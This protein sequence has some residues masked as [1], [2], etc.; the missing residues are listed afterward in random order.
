MKNK[1][2]KVFF[3]F[4]YNFLFIHFINSQSLPPKPAY[5]FN[6]KQLHAGHSLTDPL[7]SPWPGAYN[8]LLADS[9]GLAGGY[10]AWGTLTGPAT[11]PGAWIRFHWDTTLTWCG[12]QPSVNCYEDN[13]N[14]RF[15]IDKWELLVITENMEGPLVLNA[16]QSRE[17]LSYFVNN[18]WQNGNN[19]NGAPT[20]LWTNWGGLDGSPYFLNNYN[21][22]ENPATFSGWRQQLDSMELGW[23]AMQDYAN[24]NRVS[25]C[26]HVYIIPGNRMMARLYDDIQQSLVPGINSINDIFTDGVHLNNLGAYLVTLIHYAC[27]FNKNPIGLSNNLD[28]I[29]VPAAFANYAQ[30][31][32]W[33]V[34]TNYPRSGIYQQNTSSINQQSST[35]S[36]KLFPNPAKEV[37]YLN[38]NDF[39][40]NKENE[41]TWNIYDIYGKK[42]LSGTQNNN[43][44][45]ID[46]LEKGVYFIVL[47]NDYLLAQKFIKQ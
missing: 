13:M 39:Q 40:L 41:I 7:F 4:I 45:N 5:P 16:H 23:Q 9:N 11:I 10:Q 32:I 12:N 43:E 30:Q 37:I 46:S 31:M 6:I 1:N 15:D 8:E 29:S 14:P 35:S 25:G 38:F 36:F 19:G 24:A 22:T 26:P 18:S 20:M 33:D 3:L 17:H 34:V 44:I 28:A 42:I 27:I 47:N 21:F 2:L